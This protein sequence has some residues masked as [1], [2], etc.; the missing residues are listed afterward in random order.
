MK[1][2]PGMLMK[3]KEREKAGGRIGREPGDWAL[4]LQWPI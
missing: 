1:V 2:T 4:G 3:T